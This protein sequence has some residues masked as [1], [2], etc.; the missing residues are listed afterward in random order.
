MNDNGDE[1]PV[2]A[3]AFLEKFKLSIKPELDKLDTLEKINATVTSIQEAQIVDKATLTTHSEKITD[4]ELADSRHEEAA[5]KNNTRI[6]AL[7]RQ[8]AYLDREL[9][10]ERGERSW[11]EQQVKKTNIVFAGIQEFEDQRNG[12]TL[13]AVLATIEKELGIRARMVSIVNCYRLGQLRPKTAAIGGARNKQQ[14]PRKILVQFNTVM[15]RNRVWEAKGKLKDRPIWLSEDYTRETERKRATLLPIMKTARGMNDYK[16]G[17]YLAGDKLVIKGKKYSADNLEELPQNLNPRN[18][19]T[20][21]EQGTT[22]FYSRHSPFSN[23]FPAPFTIGKSTYCCSEQCYF[24]SKAEFL[25]DLEQLDIIMQQ[26]DGRDSLTE[27]KK[28]KNMNKKNWEEAEEEAMKRANK[29]KYDQNPGLL[30]NLMATKQSHLAEAS[31]HD[32][33]WGIGYAINNEEKTQHL[34]WGDNKFG[35]VLMSLRSDYE[36]AANIRQMETQ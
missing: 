10:K 6:V 31:P 1:L 30:T 8:C 23:H 24:A 27:G 18:T 22:F 4:L 35:H 9:K 26:V 7:E 25:G 15:D 36:E 16:E 2:W 20:V 13:G 33:K 32:R 5:K 14:G 29:A 19:S 3:D 21:E 34:L 28:I 12:G 11:I 17:T